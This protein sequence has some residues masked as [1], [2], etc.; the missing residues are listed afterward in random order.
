M[1]AA[2]MRGVGLRELAT[3]KATDVAGLGHRR[4]SAV[5]NVTV[6]D[7]GMG[8]Q[9]KEQGA[10][11][12]Q[13]E[14]SAKALLE[15][16]EEVTR[17]HNSFAAAGADVLTTN[18]FACVPFHLGEK[19]FA[20]QGSQLAKLAAQLARGA[21]DTAGGKRR[22]RPLR[23]AG[24]LPPPHGSYRPDQ[25]K[26]TEAIDVLTTLAEAQVPYVDLWLAETLSSTS[27]LHAVTAALTTLSGPALPLWVSF[28]LTDDPL[29]PCG[30]ARLR[31]GEPV[32]DAVQAAHAAGAE[33]LLFNCSV[34]EVMAPALAAARAAD[35]KAV[36]PLLLGVYANNFEPISHGHEA[37]AELNKLRPGM[38][39]EVY[40]DLARHWIEDGAAIV[41]GCCGIGPEHIAVIDAIR[42]EAIQVAARANGSNGAPTSE[43]EAQH[44]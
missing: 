7:G 9:L 16:P 14:W 33:A 40:A 42:Q 24:C 44:K 29:P 5:A 1:A 10:P 18:A 37:N 41:G 30:T 43:E 15:A 36:P 11:F 20:A 27:E 8:R 19:L 25:F 35:A 17:A 22:E 38:S 34:P 13:P 3:A 4:L 28:T 31:S 6:L 2:A 39:P 32:E 21:A 26:P 23:V 12:G